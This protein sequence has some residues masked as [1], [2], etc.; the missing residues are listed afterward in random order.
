MGPDVDLHI[1]SVLKILS[2]MAAQFLPSRSASTAQQG[3]VHSVDL[4]NDPNFWR[5][6]RCAMVRTSL[7]AEQHTFLMANMDCIDSSLAP[8]HLTLCREVHSK[9]GLRSQ[10]SMFIVSSWGIICCSDL[11]Q[12]SRNGAL[13]LQGST[14]SSLCKYGLSLLRAALPPAAQKAPPWSAF[15]AL[16]EL[17]DEY[18]LHLIQVSL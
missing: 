2:Q 18:A 11:S 5:I 10:N 8:A 14:Q 3:T 7:Q 9:Q 17:L 6:V 1:I 16:Y 4:R 12:P 13:L 15:L